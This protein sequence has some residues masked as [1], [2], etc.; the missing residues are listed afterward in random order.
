MIG[1]ARENFS[2]ALSTSACTSASLLGLSCSPLCVLG[3]ESGAFLVLKY[4]AMTSFSFCKKILCKSKYIY[5][6]STNVNTIH[7]IP[8]LYFGCSIFKFNLSPGEHIL[9][10]EKIL[11]VDQEVAWRGKEKTR[12]RNAWEGSL[13]SLG[14]PYSVCWKRRWPRGQRKA[15]QL[16]KY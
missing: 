11:D 9:R 15:L 8:H 10:E 7:W 4:I 14:P 6:H 5:S 2:L 16:E 1:E 13:K 12:W 3:T